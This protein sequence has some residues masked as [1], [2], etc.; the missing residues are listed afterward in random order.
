[1]RTEPLRVV[2]TSPKPNA[3]TEC[4]VEFA[5]W[6]ATSGGSMQEGEIVAS[7]NPGPVGKLHLR[8]IS[9]WLSGSVNTLQW[10]TWYGMTVFYLLRSE[11]EEMLLRE[12]NLGCSYLFAVSLL[13]FIIAGTYEEALCLLKPRV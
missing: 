6:T 10:L 8:I 7:G 1:M 5:A 11:N 9:R 2:L 3:S 12:W 13:S 4:M